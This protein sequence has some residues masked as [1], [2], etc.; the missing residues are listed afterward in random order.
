MTTDDSSNALNLD[1]KGTS[2]FVHIPVEETIRTID[3]QP[4]YSHPSQ[5]Q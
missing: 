1:A 5:P 2:E 4:Q 3:S